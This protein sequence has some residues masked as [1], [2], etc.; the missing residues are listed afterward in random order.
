MILCIDIGNTNTVVGGYDGDKL[1]FR[2]RIATD[3]SLTSD[4]YAVELKGL[5]DLHRIDAA[6]FDGAA[7]SS[8]VPQLTAPLS[9]AVVSVVGVYPIALGPDNFS[10]LDIK[11]DNPLELGNDLAAAAVATKSKYPLPCIIVDMGTA[12]KMTV[13]SADGEFLGGA[14]APGLHVSV[15]S[16]IGNASLLTGIPLEAPENVIGTNTADCM[17][18]GAVIGA[19]AMID[20]M[21][22]RIAE[23]LGQAPKVVATGGLAHLVVPC[24]RKQVILDDDLVLD[25]IRMIYETNKKE[26]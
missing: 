13:L 14:I 23:Q 21:C 25:G 18:S 24:C 9:R 6:D 16:L 11:L 7:I 22:E 26:G 5:L 17:K 15:E 20:G 8:V 12:T 2:A 1:V 3:A 10:D 4:Q 19:A